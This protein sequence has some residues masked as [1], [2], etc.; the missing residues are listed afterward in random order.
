M[1]GRVK[2]PRP[3]EKS[4]AAHH[5]RDCISLARDDGDFVYNAL[6]ILAALTILRLANAVDIKRQASVFDKLH[7]K[8]K[9]VRILDK[10]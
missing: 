4:K 10:I 6:V 2:K 9:N 1:S 5:N 7:M 8:F 3:N